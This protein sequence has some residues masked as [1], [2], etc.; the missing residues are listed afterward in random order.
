MRGPNLAAGLAVAAI[1]AAPLVLGDYQLALLTYV[2]LSAIVALGLV[3]MTGKAGLSSFGQA[4]FVGIGAYV[5]AIVSMQAGLSPWLTLPLA[6]LAS[7]LCALLGA[8]VMVRLSGHYLSLAT[9]A[10]GAAMFFLFGGLDITGG[11][12]G[13]SGIP[14]VAAFGVTFTQAVPGYAFVWAA[15][16]GLLWALGNL[17]DSRTGRAIRALK[18]HAAMAEAMGIDTAAAKT[19]V[20]VIACVMAG[21]VGWF[22][23]HFQRFVNPSPFSLA[24]GIEYVFMAVL[25]GAGML[26][27]AVAGALI[28]TLLKPLLQAGLPLVLGMQGN[29]EGVVFGA[30][31][32]LIFQFADDGLLPRLRRL[33]GWSDITPRPI[34]P[35]ALPGRPL[36]AGTGPVLR[37]AGAR[38][39]FGGVVANEDVG[40]AVQAAEIV[41]LIGPNGA[42]KSTFFD[43]VTGVTRA[44]A[45]VFELDGRSIAGLGARAIARLGV[46][47]SFQHVRLVGD[48]SVIENVAL[49]AHPRGRRGVIAGLLRAD[50]AEERALLAC[51]MRQLERV[52]LAEL[53]WQPAAAL[54]LGQQR[55]LEIARALAA[56]PRLLLLDEPAAGLRHQEK[57][58]LAALIRALR[59]EGMAVLLVEHDMDFVM[60][61]A[62]RV[63]VLEFGRVIAAGTPRDVQ[64]DARVQ[65]AY[66]GVPA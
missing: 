62:D 36:A 27:G 13:L 5:S 64:H 7:G 28:V 19:W 61:L 10:F 52:G 30:I 56:D 51:A 37:V 54:A 20:F 2:G 11:Q 24:Q 16:L 31:V 25:G 18:E 40:L 49:G 12:S 22:Y 60:T 15:V 42:G 38:R 1:A 48:M 6:L 65:D 45:G 9:I 50:R 53:A 66:L 44:D 41:A 32:I 14:A 43:L 8:L 3:L 58:A 39:A 26:W 59:D 63:V 29:F 57:Q 35:A 47:R 34:V 4:A 55:I 33:L 46:A 17:L 21:F 23:A